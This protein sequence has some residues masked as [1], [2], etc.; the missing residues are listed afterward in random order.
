M[1]D[2]VARRH[3]LV[4]VSAPVA[5]FW[6]VVAESP[7]LRAHTRLLTE[8][9]ERDLGRMLASSVDAPTGDPMARLIAAVLV[10][11]WRVSFREAVR[12]HRS[13]PA[14]TTREVLLE[15]LDDG[16]TAASAAARGT[17]YV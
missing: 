5:S 14:A 4:R 2:L 11:A 13:T 10:G 15:L 8:Q 3:G 12:R 16:F 17:A 7:A 6:K 1:H 9:L